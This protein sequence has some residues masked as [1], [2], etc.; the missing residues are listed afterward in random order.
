MVTSLRPWTLLPDPANAGVAERWFDGSRPGAQPAP[1]PGVIQQVFPDALGVAWYWTVLD[2]DAPIPPDHRLLLRFGGADYLATVWVDGIAVIEHEGVDEAFVADLTDLSGREG[3]HVVAVRVFHPTEERMDG[4]VI[5]ETA[6]RNKRSQGYHP[7]WLHNVGGL[8]GRVAVLVVPAVR[9]VDV[10]ARPRLEDGLVPVEITTRSDLR[11]TTPGILSVAIGP[12]REGSTDARWERRVELAPGLVTHRLTLSVAAPHPWDIDDPFLYR[13]S[14]DLRVADRQHRAPALVH[15]RAVRVGFRDFRV[16]DGYYRLNGRRLFM[17][18]SHS[19]N[20]FPIGQVVPPTP[21]LVRRDLLNAKASGFNMLRFMSGLPLPEQ[22]DCADEIGLLIYEEP[23]VS[24]LLQ[25]SEAMVQRYDRALEAM[26]R[27]DRSHPSVVIWGLLTEGLDG[28]VFRHALTTLDT[29]RALDPTRLVMLNS[30]RFDAKPAIGSVSNPG[31]TT[32][33]HTWGN[34]APE[35]PGRDLVPDAATGWLTAASWING[36]LSLAGAIEGNGDTHTY[37]I[38]PHTQG[39]IEFLRTLGR[40][41]KPHMLSEYGIGSLMNVIGEIRRFEAAGARPDLL[42]AALIRSMAERFL[43][44]LSRYGLDDLYPF[45][46]DLLIEAQRRH[47]RH[48]ELG[49]D[50]VRSNP[51]LAGWNITG[52]LDHALTGEG[53]WTFWRQWKPGIVDVLSDGW[54]PLR[55]CLFSQPPHVEAGRD[56]RLEAVLADDAALAPGTYRARFRLHGEW[57][58][59][60]EASAPVV[61][62]SDRDRPLA[63]PVLDVTIAAPTAAGVYTFAAE[64]L[65]GGRPAGGRLAVHVAAPVVAPATPLGVMTFGLDPSVRAWL[66]DHGVVVQAFA[67]ASDASARIIL[68]GDPG[69]DV[70]GAWARLHALVAAGATAV[71]LAPEGLR[72]G[73]SS[74]GWLPLEGAGRCEPFYDW[75]YHREWVGARHAALDGLDARGVLDW[76]VWGPLLGRRMYEGMPDGADVAVAAFAVGYSTPGGYAS[77]IVLGAYPSG[78]GRVIL[79][80]LEVLPNLDRHPVADRLLMNLIRWAAS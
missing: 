67:E 14:A 2:V 11:S 22:L 31:G 64:L 26:L 40:D 8:T 77:G 16:V 60:W 69:P 55:W 19:G 7:G 15:D 71:F 57:G 37:P 21:D 72:R 66:A 41:T 45:P 28:P 50:I 75:V 24:W 39:A 10:V 20:H 29:I 38:V 47:G 74:L 9:I 35:A 27:R 23:M 56:L 51:K 59:A 48:R 3:D 34:E 42:D 79:N 13:V 65:A 17:R 46:E 1:V 76:D 33:E 12:D 43:A 78:S 70:D 6:H 53:F 61:I 52:L 32:W 68:V 5:G 58:I 54:A 80:A 49:F 18:S 36:D 4:I 25:D 44:D 30:G 73:D 63:I 62:A